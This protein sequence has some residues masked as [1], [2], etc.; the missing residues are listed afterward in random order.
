MRNTRQ[1]LALL[2]AA[3]AAL[4]AV[5]CSG[6]DDWQRKDAWRECERAISD[7]PEA[8]APPCA[9][10]RMCANEAPL[11]PEARGKLLQMIAATPE[12]PEP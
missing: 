11:S 5:R 7:W 6:G 10:L 4:I 3:L 8:P 9:A 2:L 12:C 1:M